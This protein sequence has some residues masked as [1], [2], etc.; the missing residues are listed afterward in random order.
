MEAAT[1]R[2]L[3]PPAL[4]AGKA[5]HRLRSDRKLVDRFRAGDESAFAV[6]YERH[7]RLVTG[8]GLGLLG[9]PEDAADLG[10]EVFLRAAA[11]LRERPPDDLRPW[12]A[13][14]ARNAAIDLARS[15][16][17]SPV[18]LTERTASH[19]VAAEPP[20]ELERRA[21]LRDLVVA[22]QALPEQQRGALVL[23]ELAGCSYADIAATLEVD[24]DAVR[25]L[26]AR[27]RLTLRR[28]REEAERL[29]CASVRAELA[30]ER[31][32]RRR[33]GAMRRHLRA[34]EE[35]R[36]LRTSLRD[37]AKSLRAL[38]PGVGGLGLWS[39]LAA[40]VRGPGLVAG[41]A[42]VKG[43]VAGQVAQVAAI[44]V[45]GVGAAEGVRS[46]A[47]AL[48]HAGGDR[49]AASGAGALRTGASALAS[50]PSQAPPL[51]RTATPAPRHEASS[52]PRSVDP[53][54]RVRGQLVRGGGD[55]LG[56]LRPG[57]L[58]PAGIGG[59]P[60][61]LAGPNGPPARPGASPGV[62]P[63][64]PAGPPPGAGQPVP[65]GDRAQP[66]PPAAA[67]RPGGPRDGSAPAGPKP[68]S[69]GAPKP[70]AGSGQQPPP[71]QPPPPRPSPSPSGARAPGSGSGPAPSEQPQ[72]AAGTPSAPASSGD[73]GLPIAGGVATP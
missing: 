62:H 59:Q 32:G 43:S 7:R 22:L 69:G 8:I 18:E 40:V 45:L 16:R 6:L 54:G 52:A 63:S 64:R 25:G 70:P 20:R 15:R 27:A 1:A 48:I 61:P 46:I 10:Q 34:C 12:L 42:M 58:A 29:T 28:A 36:A 30:A 17:A 24:E 38:G 67:P 53:K 47:P 3:R 49:N 66:A 72:S 60:P 33:S 35:C 26:I 21:E 23:R 31:D 44:A 19:G 11:Q 56:P 41:G 73:G 9:S 5:L 2:A 4:P 51:I 14:V 68:P 55:R 71:T 50:R 39:G 57:R 37:D 65:R 13:R